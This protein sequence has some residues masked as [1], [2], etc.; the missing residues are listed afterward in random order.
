LQTREHRDPAHPIHPHAAQFGHLR[1]IGDWH[2]H[3]AHGSDLP[4]MQDA[5][6]WAGTADALGRESYVSW[7]IAPNAN[8]YGWTM[9]RF[10]GWITER[11]GVPRSRSVAGPAS[12]A[13][14][15]EAASKK[16]ESRRR[17]A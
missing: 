7:V 14:D 9:P 2:A 17:R 6:A 4:S 1:L 5:R 11:V 12:R 15:A 16:A 13:A 8:G 3:C 10:S